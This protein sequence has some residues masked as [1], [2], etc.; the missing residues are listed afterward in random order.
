MSTYLADETDAA[1]QNVVVGQPMNA[2]GHSGMPTLD[3][4]RIQVDFNA[5]VEQ[6]LV[7]LSREDEKRDSAGDVIQLSEGLRVYLYMPDADDDGVPRDLL[8][9]GVVE[10]NRAQDWSASTRWCCRIDEWEQQ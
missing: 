1:A 3:R 7:L 9:T 10:L 6:D 4:P 2:A 8:A 5:M